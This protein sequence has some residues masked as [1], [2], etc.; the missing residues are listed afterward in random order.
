MFKVGGLSTR[1]K[2]ELFLI[3]TNIAY[4]PFFYFMALI[5]AVF[6]KGLELNIFSVLL[7]ILTIIGFEFVFEILIN[8]SLNRKQQN[9]LFKIYALLSLP[10]LIPFVIFRDYT[11]LVV[12]ITFAILSALFEITRYKFASSRRILLVALISFFLVYFLS[13][14]NTNYIIIQIFLLALFVLAPIRLVQHIPAFHIEIDKPSQEIIDKLRIIKEKIPRYSRNFRMENTIPMI[15]NENIYFVTDNKIYDEHAKEVKNEKIKNDLN[16]LLEVKNSIVEIFK[17]HKIK[18]NILHIIFVQLSSLFFSYELLKYAN[19]FLYENYDNLD[20]A[21]KSELDKKLTKSDIEL[22]II[23]DDLNEYLFKLLTISREFLNVPS[24][25]LLSL[26]RESQKIVSNKII[27]SQVK[28]KIDDRV[29]IAE[30]LYK[31][32]KAYLLGSYYAM[33]RA[34]EEEINIINDFNFS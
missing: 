17:K 27:K 9:N 1:M 11:F 2:Y 13:Q 15:L 22:S 34:I 12:P 6:L 3:S 14:S 24:N 20:F 19:K 23:H 25:I 7:F 28:K 18:F 26:I 31:N 4:K 30:K 5:N 8:P 10:S 29:K 33:R 16:K 32:R 21:G